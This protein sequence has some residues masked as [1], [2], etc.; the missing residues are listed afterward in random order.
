[1][2]QDLTTPRIKITTREQLSVLPF[3]YLLNV[4]RI[5]IAMI[6]I[7]L[8]AEYAEVKLI[9]LRQYKTSMLIYI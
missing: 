3:R 6:K 1:M 9:I 2:S 8:K 5:A 7:Q 4:R